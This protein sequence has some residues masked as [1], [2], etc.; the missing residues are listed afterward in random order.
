MIP[1]YNR[2][3]YLGR[4]IN[5]V[6]EQAPSEAEMQIEVI[7]NASPDFDVAAFVREIGGDRVCFHRHETNIGLVEN[8]NSCIRRA[9][10]Q[11][12][13]ILHDDD[14]VRPNFYRSYRR[15]IEAHPQVDLVFSRSIAIDEDDDWEYLTAGPP[16]MPRAGIWDDGLFRL[17]SENPSDFLRC[18]SIVVARRAYEA[19]GGFE[20]RAIYTHDWQMWLRIAA[21]FEVGYLHEPLALYRQHPEGI[22]YNLISHHDVLADIER[23]I[24]IDMALLPP[25]R[26]AA[27]R[28]GADRTIAA[29]A[30]MYR[31]YV[32][33]RGY[34]RIELKYSR[35]LYRHAPSLRNL[36]PIFTSLAR[37]MKMQ[38]TKKK[39]TKPTA[40]IS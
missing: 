35:A 11:W 4:T 25:E 16:T 39:S 37:V 32:R 21:Q 9:R 6:L 12:V 28:P 29:I 10:G 18:P 2:I 13:H 30:E 33:E 40:S 14:M 7:D 24:N 31:W 19:V 26:R 23:T 34:H 1:T 27:A 36:L 15:W 8:W 3:E 38:V 5:S 22:T 20:A 17:V